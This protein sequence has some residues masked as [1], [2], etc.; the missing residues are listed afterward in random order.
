MNPESGIV[1][2]T[3]QEE[4]ASAHTVDRMSD[5]H[6]LELT[7]G[8]HFPPTSANTTV[9][10]ILGLPKGTEFGIDYNVWQTG[11]HFKGLQQVPCGMHFVYYSTG[12]FRSGFFLNV[13][14]AGQLF[15]WNWNPQNETLDR[16]LDVDQLQRIKYN[17]AEFIPHLGPYP[18]TSPRITDT[19]EQGQTNTL[20]KWHRLSSHISQKV[21][22]RTLSESGVVSAMT[23]T[24]HFSD[25]P[26]TAAN[27]M[28]NSS[29][30]TL[31]D[32]PRPLD[33]ASVA[34][35]PP[36]AAACSPLERDFDRIHFAKVDLKRSFPP[37]ATGSQ[38]TKYSLD[39]SYLLKSLIEDAYAGDY[40]LLLGEFQLSFVIFLL[41]QVYDGF[42]QWKV[43]VQLVCLSRE[44]IV[45][46]P[47]FFAE[48]VGLLKIQLEECPQDFF[49]DALAS[50]SFLHAAIKSIVA[51]S[52][53][54]DTNAPTMVVQAVSVL[55]EFMSSRFDWDVSETLD[56]V[57][58]EDHPFQ[59]EYEP[60]IIK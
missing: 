50:D 52:R 43:L 30:S 29:A 33:S 47:D 58:E 27:S 25:I 36:T 15:A 22:V 5:H 60:V 20:Q 56:E 13:T 24:S 3:T 46:L 54:T 31:Q 21:V 55:A 39:K 1:Q 17:L 14:T 57:D 2:R 26:L 23:S 51:T 44:C 18:A 38:V 32:A 11:P 34:D 28:V 45:D 19:N 9:L 35:L 40:T 48:F 16:E 7:S 59:D 41:G 37:G 8:E 4:A 6:Q 53:D 12:N 10:L 42:D 49:H